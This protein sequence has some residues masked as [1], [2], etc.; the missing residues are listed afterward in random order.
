MYK[1]I[2]L[3]GKA[4]A[5]K[6]TILKYIKYN[7]IASKY[8]NIIISCTTRP[9]RDYEVDGKDYYFLTHEEFSKKLIEDEIL[10][11][12]FFNE[13][14]Y[15]TPIEALRE[16]KVNIG[17]FNPAGIEALKTHKNM[18]D[19]EVFYID[20]IDKVRLIRQLEREQKPDI[21]EIYRRYKADFEDFYDL[22]FDYTLLINN[23]EEDI[24]GCAHTIFTT[25][26]SM[27]K[28]IS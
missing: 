26:Y 22:D 10:E 13:W 28:E 16:D 9:K 8:I 18:I 1:V 21:E 25:I 11:A 27:Y 7:N 2:A 20:A 23:K 12:A 15:G 14:C 4:G 17:V 3:I 5:G 19:L 6:D 24:M